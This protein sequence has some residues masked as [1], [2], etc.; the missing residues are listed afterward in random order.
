MPVVEK[1]LNELGIVLPDAPKPVAVYLPACQCV[2]RLVFVS[3]QDCRKN[4]ELL[5]Q[6][7]LGQELTVEQGKA[8]ARQSMLNCLAALKSCIKDLDRVKHIV[9]VNGYI[10][11]A[12]E[13]GDQPYVLN[14]ASELLVDIF[15]EAGKHA[16][17]ALGINELP[18][19]TPIEI[20]MVVEIG[21]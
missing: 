2:D 14:G 21:D 3:G 7:K 12:P 16:R 18:F 15:G 8:C 5:H 10:A 17:A 13:F 4:G 1:R 6:G 9:K 11:S 19:G 20:E